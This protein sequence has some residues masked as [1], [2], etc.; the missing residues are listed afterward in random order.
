MM[1]PFDENDLKSAVEALRSGGVI[2][3]PTDT[4]WGLGC[5]PSDGNAVDKVFEI[6]R[7]PAEKSMILI[8]DSLTM[9]ERYTSD[10]NAVAFELVEVS[11]GPLTLVLP[12]RQN[13]V[14]PPL[15]S[16]DGFIGIRVTSDEFCTAMIARFRKPIVSTSANIS[17]DPSPA[18]FSEIT[19]GIS[20]AADYVVKYRQNDTRRAQPSPVIKVDKNGV[21]Q[22]LRK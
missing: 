12:A 11:E 20:G 2:L 8:V 15:V 7:R 6:K 21:I 22:I 18:I 14:A 10:V 17:G 5:D 4:I 3:Y 19:P 16:S 13:L 1:W 9:L